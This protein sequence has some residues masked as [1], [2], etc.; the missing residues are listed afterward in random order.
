[1]NG[2]LFHIPY[3]TFLIIFYTKKNA[4]QSTIIKAKKQTTTNIMMVR[5]ANFGYNPQTAVSNTFQ[6]NDTSLSK[7]KISDLAIEEFD[8]FVAKLLA[9][10]IN[11]IVAQDADEPKKPDAVFCNNWVSFHTNGT[12]ILYPML[13]PNRRLERQE[14]VIEEI[15][16]RFEV[17]RRMDLSAHEN[18]NR[19]L[20]GTGSMILDRMNR[21]VYACLSPRTDADLLD[22]FCE[23]AEY[24]KVVF[25]SVDR[26]GQEIYHT[27]VMM[28][29]GDKFV[30]ISMATIPNEAERT[31]LLERF[32][33]TNKEV[34]D[35]TME[36]IEAFAG[37]M[38]QVE[39]TDGKT[40]LVMSEQAFKSLREDQ[41]EAIERHTA[42]LHAPIYTIEKLGGGSARCMMAEVFSP[43]L[44]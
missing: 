29:M 18:E 40:F 13:T 28:A 10:G 14:N 41:I 25:Y 4:M 39:N 19:I 2:Q 7:A 20:E 37:N 15:T 34:I 42:I 6:D 24:E 33:Q 22:E 31:M 3:S 27:N 1:M 12:M 30:V 17:T 36:Q 43:K 32:R 11:V 16:K 44:S 38:L 5:P 26:N 8:G 23:W 35:L 9:A 21:L